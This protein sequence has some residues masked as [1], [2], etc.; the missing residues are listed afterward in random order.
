[1][2]KLLNLII[3]F[4]NIFVGGVIIYF[5]C[6]LNIIPFKYIMI[7]SVIL[8]F[9]LL[10]IILLETR[11]KLIIKMIGYLLSLVLIVGCIIIIHFVDDT[12]D[13]LNNA[14]GNADGHHVNSYYIVKYADEDAE[15]IYYNQNLNGRIVGYYEDIPNIDKALKKL[16]EISDVSVKKYDSLEDIED[17]LKNREI[18]CFILEEN[19]YNYVIEFV[20]DKK[21][22]KIYSYDIFIKEEI[23]IS[24]NK[25]VF[26][27]YI[28]GLDFT[29]RNTD[30]NMIVTVNKKTHKILLT[31]TPRDYYVE[32]DGK[33][34]GKDLLGYAGVWGI[35]TSIKTLENL[36]DINIDYYVRLNTNGLVKLVDTLG[37]LEFCSDFSFTTSHATVLG[38]YDD[39]TGDKLRVRKG[40]HE[41]TG[42]EILTIARERLA[43][44]AG[45]RQ[46]QKNC[47]E[48]IKSL[49]YKILRPENLFSYNK[50]L[51]AVGNMYTTTISRELVSDFVKETINKPSNWIFVQQSVNGYGSSGKVHF[52]NYYD[53][54]MIPDMNSVKQ[55]SNMIKYI[56]NEG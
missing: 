31:S 32:I 20:V 9:F 29:E 37:T 10:L 19:L 15:D 8:L 53:Y 6:S 52:S 13:F 40:C 51:D 23:N 54:I 49:F 56:M 28:A 17:A 27:I 46:R 12:N 21:L 25:D 44:N 16:N 24:D 39:K 30:F 7:L 45:D 38:T 4:I 5:V 47:Q 41:Y 50:I 22:Q 14:F 43:Y 48:I 36:Y 26:N 1:M 35:N 33:N 2:R 18:D 3:P 55:A 11:K 42:I 34:G